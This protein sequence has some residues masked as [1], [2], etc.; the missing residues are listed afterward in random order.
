MVIG[1]LL[2]AQEHGQ[3]H[4]VVVSQADLQSLADVLGL[5]GGEPLEVG[6]EI[7]P[8]LVDQSHQL[9]TCVPLDDGLWRHLPSLRQ[10]AGGG[11]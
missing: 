9:M 5:L 1:G 8:A 6:R 7:A 10:G 3:C 2:C 4:V 11:Q